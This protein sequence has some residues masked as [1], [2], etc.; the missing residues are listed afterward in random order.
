MPPP[1]ELDRRVAV[2]IAAPQP[3]PEDVL[4]PILWGLEEEG[5]PAEIQPASAGSVAEMA[6]RAADGSPLN[7]GIA[8][9]GAERAVALHHRDL[10]ADR[11]LFVLR[12][13]ALQTP[14]LRRL[15]ANA[16]RLV[17]G[18]PLAVDD[19]PAAAAPAA[20]PRD[21][22]NEIADLV[23]ARLA[24]ERRRGPMPSGPASRRPE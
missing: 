24:R 23:V 14:Q 9:S 6:K 15:G 18:N 21:L 8:V 7:V 16:A 3:L 5:I 2:W 10:A 17:K 19:A 11:P 4:A 20:I 1:S 12:P 13:P 22:V